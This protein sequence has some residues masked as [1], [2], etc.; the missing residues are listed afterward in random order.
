M[1]SPHPASASGRFPLLFR[2]LGASCSRWAA[3]L[4][5]FAGAVGGL[6]PA[7]AATLTT[8][9]YPAATLTRSTTFT[10]ATVPIAAIEASGKITKVG[11]TAMNLNRTG[12][13]G[14]AITGS[15]TV[16]GKFGYN[17]AD[18]SSTSYPQGMSTSTDSLGGIGLIDN[19]IWI[20]QTWDVPGNAY[21]SLLLFNWNTKAY[22]WVSLVDPYTDSNEVGANFREIVGRHGDGLVWFKNYLYVADACHGFMVFDTNH[23]WE[24]ASP[25]GTTGYDSTAHAFHA[26]G[27]AY[28]MPK[29][30]HYRYT[31]GWTCNPGA[32]ALAGCFL[33]R[34]TPSYLVAWG[35][36]GNIVKWALDNTTGLLVLDGSGIAQPAGGWQLSVGSS[37]LF[38]ATIVGSNLYAN[39]Q[40]NGCTN[41]GE[42]YKFP[43]TGGTD[44][45]S[46]P[47]N[48]CTEAL[49]ND[50]Y[51]N[52]IWMVSEAAGNKVTWTIRP[53]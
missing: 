13:A 30:G 14:G 5:S 19:C 48:G 21:L 36:N 51:W 47:I 42:L 35:L 52:Q 44:T 17:P 16:T 46:T 45:S 7:R 40:I 32:P 18:A 37:S 15:Y 39:L 11:F 53:P 9:S 28:V 34:G 6:P 10:D 33:N 38:A 50:P 26:A 43:V 27:R 2:V 20:A 12:S 4:L 1:K 25:N 3:L 41:A 24:I 8:A 49:V 31:G 23:V 22:R 29:I